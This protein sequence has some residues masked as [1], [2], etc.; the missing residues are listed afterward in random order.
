MNKANERVYVCKLYESK[1]DCQIS[2]AIYAIKKQFLFKQTMTKVDYFV[3][4]QT[5]NVIGG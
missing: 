4:V 3:F 2:L 1:E 5:K